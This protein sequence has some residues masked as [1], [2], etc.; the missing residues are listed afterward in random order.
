MKNG[1]VMEPCEFNRNEGRNRQK[2]LVA[3][4]H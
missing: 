1:K 3:K 4:E 2:S